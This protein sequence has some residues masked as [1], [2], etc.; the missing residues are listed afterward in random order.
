ML[1]PSPPSPRQG[2]MERK[3]GE[4]VTEI[5]SPN[6]ELMLLEYREDGVL[7]L[8]G[9]K[10]LR[11][12]AKKMIPTEAFDTMIAVKALDTAFKALD[13]NYPRLGDLLVME[14]G[15]GKASPESRIVA[16]C[17]LLFLLKE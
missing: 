2:E 13:L 6:A 7:R 1:A 15:D 16:I 17:T 3:G 12:E 9:L 8:E 5:L 4:D 11:D 10:T 14:A